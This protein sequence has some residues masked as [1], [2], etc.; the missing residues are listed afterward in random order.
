MPSPTTP[1]HS[2]SHT[3]IL[4][5]RVFNRMATS[6]GTLILT[7]D[8]LSLK[9]RWSARGIGTITSTASCPSGMPG[10]WA[11]SSSSHLPASACWS[12]CATRK[13]R[14]LMH[15][16]A[17]SPSGSTPNLLSGS[18]TDGCLVPCAGHHGLS[19]PCCAH[20][21]PNASLTFHP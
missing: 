18:I 20:G 14:P 12:C 11:S 8:P 16:L 5:I 6:A 19:G 17:L 2:I 4:S 10:T 7:A 1:S 13:S 21:R 3:T 9:I 15:S